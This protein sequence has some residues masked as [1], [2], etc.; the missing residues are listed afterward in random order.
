[1]TPYFVSRLLYTTLYNRMI[2][3]ISVSQRL[4]IT[5]SVPQ[6]SLL[7]NEHVSTE[8]GN[9]EACSQVWSIVLLLT[10]GVCVSVGK[11]I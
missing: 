10:F 2:V 7:L 8:N 1:M 6:A 3:N 11:T 9:L 4:P 5:A